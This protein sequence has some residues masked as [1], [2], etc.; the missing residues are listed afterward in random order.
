MITSNNTQSGSTNAES[1]T[2]T[3][4]TAVNAVQL[5]AELKTQTSKDGT[6]IIQGDTT[7][8]GAALRSSQWTLQEIEA[9]LAAITYT[10]RQPTAK[11]AAQTNVVQLY[12]TIPAQITQAQADATTIATMVAGQPLNAAQ[13]T[14]L[15]NHANGWVNLLQALQSLVVAAG[16]DS[17]PLNF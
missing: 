15:T 9:A 4:T 10:P 11:Q 17:L 1:A 7:V 2:I 14:A 5:M 3:A 16:L 13:I 8:A 6:L 12:S